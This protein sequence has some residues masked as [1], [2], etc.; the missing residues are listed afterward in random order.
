MAER[1][2][3]VAIEG[4]YGPPL[5]GIGFVVEIRDQVFTFVTHKWFLR[6]LVPCQLARRKLASSACWRSRRR[7]STDNP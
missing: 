2:W 1:P 4:F 5:A 3:V 7:R 6:Y